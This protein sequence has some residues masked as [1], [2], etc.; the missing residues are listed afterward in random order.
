MELE[1][2]ESPNGGT[3]YFLCRPGANEGEPGMRNPDVM[4]IAA[5]TRLHA[6]LGDLNLSNLN[7]VLFSPC[8]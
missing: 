1:L 3:R 2:G 5:M 8:I 7:T 4:P 6:W